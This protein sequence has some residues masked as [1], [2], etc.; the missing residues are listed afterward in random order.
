MA[1]SRLIFHL[2][3]CS[4]KSGAFLLSTRKSAKCWRLGALVLI[5]A[6]PRSCLS[7]SFGNTHTVSCLAWNSARFSVTATSV[8]QA[9]GFEFT[10]EQI[11]L[12]AMD[13]QPD[14]FEDWALEAANL[15]T[16]S[17]A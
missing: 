1:S 17:D 16:A 4:Y 10:V 9:L 13:L 15:G 2:D 7:P 5:P 12:R 6:E 11:E 3:G 8:D 14:L